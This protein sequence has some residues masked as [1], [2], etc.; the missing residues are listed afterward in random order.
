MNDSVN[1]ESTEITRLI[2]QLN[3][4]DLSTAIN[5][6][7]SLG[8]VGSLA[9]KVVPQLVIATTSQHTKLKA[10]ACASLGR[11]AKNGRL[12]IPALSISLNSDN[13][14]VR[15]YAAAALVEFGDDVSLI[16]TQLIKSTRDS[17]A[18]VREFI[19]ECFKNVDVL[20]ED[21]QYIQDRCADESYYVRAAAKKILIKQDTTSRINAA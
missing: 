16:Y 2:K 7:R 20:A 19:M 18:F 9:E 11:I 5:A 12:S 14:S 17:D 4:A 3:S 1:I 10:L 8:I 15:Q 21:I 13:V 6:A